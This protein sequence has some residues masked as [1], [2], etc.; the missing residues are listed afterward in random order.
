MME[1]FPFV[2]DALLESSSME[3]QRFAAMMEW[4]YAARMRH[5]QEGSLSRL[6]VPID[7]AP[8]MR[9]LADST[10]DSKSRAVVSSLLREIWRVFAGDRLDAGLDHKQQYVPKDRGTGNARIKTKQSRGFLGRY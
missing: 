6:V 5:S 1:W 4:M 7:R 2:L 9:Y 8:L 10:T 3:A